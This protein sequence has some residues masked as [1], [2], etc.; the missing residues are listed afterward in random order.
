[1]QSGVGNDRRN[2]L[3]VE[4]NCVSEG[5]ATPGFSIEVFLNQIVF[6]WWVWLTADSLE[7]HPP[8]NPSL[9]VFGL[10]RLAG[11]FMYTL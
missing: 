1:M 7:P 4:P 5:L 6:L 3:A 11:L 10:D 8:D 2:L 9:K